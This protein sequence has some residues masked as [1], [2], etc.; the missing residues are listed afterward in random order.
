MRLDDLKRA[1]EVEGLTDKEMALRLGISRGHWNR[2]KNGKD[3]WND[4]IEMKATRA[5]PEIFL[6]VD[7]PNSHD[8]IT[9][10]KDNTQNAHES[11]PDKNPGGILTRVKG[12]F[13]RRQ[14]HGI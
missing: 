2:L 12:I 14:K 5:F 3:G 7:I 4:K 9:T 11:P 6:P 8:R 10:I 1:Q 13:R